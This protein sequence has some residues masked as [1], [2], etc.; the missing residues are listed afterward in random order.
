MNYIVSNYY[1][2]KSGDILRLV[3][4]DNE[5]ELLQFE[6]ITNKLLF[7]VSFEYEV[8]P[9]SKIVEALF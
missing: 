7:F 2:D 8:T 1:I 6:N 5:Y 9:V 3:W 4:I